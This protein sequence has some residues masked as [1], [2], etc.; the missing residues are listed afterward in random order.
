MT[1]AAAPVQ[2][3]DRLTALDTLRGF[4]LLGILV[5]N[6]QAFSMPDLAYMNPLA[7]GDLTGANL[8]VWVVSHIFFDQKFMTI[9]SV[10]F[11]AGIVL[12]TTKA[13]TKGER[14]A[15]LH[16]RRMAWLLAFGLVHAYALW[17]GD[18]LTTYAVSA[19]IVYPLR[20]L[21]PRTLFAVGL[22]LLAVG[23]VIWLGIGY[24]MRYWPQDMITGFYQENWQ[25]TAEGLESELTAYRG[26]WLTQMGARVPGSLEWQTLGFVLWGFWRAGGLMA[27]GMALFKWGVIAG[28]RDS[29]FYRRV[30]LVALP[31]GLALDAYGTYRNFAVNWDVR[32]SFFF[33]TQWN[34]WASLFISASYAAVVLL[35][36]KASA[37]SAFVQRLS[38]V[39][40]MAFTN[41]L[42][43]TLICTTIFYGHGFG[44]FGAV[45]RT[46]QAAI[47]VAIW[48][49]QLIVS[50]I[51]LRH[52]HFG[53]FEWLWRSLTY[54]KRQPL[55]R[56]DV[57]AVPL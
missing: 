25:P 56:G 3:A 2:Q 38:A 32:Y 48:M 20:G 17:T 53:P 49:L 36:V 7:Y 47:V 4:A 18:I 29:R 16:Y 10:L 6:I 13:E 54:W 5:M 23:A 30:L 11:G 57:A 12:F 27:I 42:L 55:R 22:L 41:Y 28:H 34:Y 21:A 39:G 45:P 8:W 46:G 26:D 1:S 43:Q 31:I 9:F 19:M 40:R 51:W 35:M 14:P 52:F 44:L 33:G 37:L 24:S 50:P 15:A